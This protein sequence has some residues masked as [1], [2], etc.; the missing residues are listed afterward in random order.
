MTG[1]SGKGDRKA[2][3]KRLKDHRRERKPLH[4]SNAEANEAEREESHDA[5]MLRRRK[6]RDF[7][8]MPAAKE[9][10]ETD[11][12]DNEI[13]IGGLPPPPTIFAAVFDILHDTGRKV[14]KQQKKKMAFEDADD[15]T[16]A[17]ESGVGE[18]TRLMQLMREAVTAEDEGS[19]ASTTTTTEINRFFH[20]PLTTLTTPQ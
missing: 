12:K 16:D 17:A 8:S 9:P 6:A 2:L 19:A 3:L 10:L 20:L 11:A 4:E 14:V 13:A 15:V 7:W 5:K 18:R 1:L